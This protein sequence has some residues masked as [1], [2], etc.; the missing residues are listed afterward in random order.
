M[1]AMVPSRV[2]YAILSIVQDD[3][4]EL[5][6]RTPYWKML[7]CIFAIASPCVMGNNVAAT[8]E[9]PRRRA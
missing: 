1:D 4:P 5:P 6:W 9:Q 3:I 2:M 8:E 7:W